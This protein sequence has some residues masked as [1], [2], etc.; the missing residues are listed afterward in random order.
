MKVG[1]VA[2]HYPRPEHWDEMISAL[3]RL[4]FP[5]TRS[6]LDSGSGEQAWAMASTAA[7][8]RRLPGTPDPTRSHRPSQSS[9]TTPDA[10]CP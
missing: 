6:W 3:A 5:W 4:K 10:H 1:L 7:T 2:V 8:I 9:Q